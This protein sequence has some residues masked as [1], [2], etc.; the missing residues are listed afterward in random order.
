MSFFLAPPPSLFIL[1]FLW[2]SHSFFFHFL[3]PFFP[4]IFLLSSPLAF[5]SSPLFF[6][7]SFFSPFHYFPLLS[8]PPSLL[9]SFHSSRG[10]S[11][12]SFIIF[13]YFSSFFHCISS[14]CLSFFLLLRLIHWGVKKLG[15]RSSIRV[16]LGDLTLWSFWTV[17]FGGQTLC[18]RMLSERLGESISLDV[19]CLHWL[20]I[21]MG[22]L[23]TAD[24]SSLPSF[25]FLSFPLFFIKQL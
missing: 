24:A 2:S 14:Y 23:N 8:F 21:G 19:N 6:S 22:T 15:F 12:T 9:P 20:L 25:F 11:S 5:F 16:L 13:H 17:Q 10:S 1:I 3:L 7:F 4:L 18:Q